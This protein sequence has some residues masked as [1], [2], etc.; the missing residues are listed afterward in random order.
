M[1]VSFATFANKQKRKNGGQP[2]FFLY[3]ELGNQRLL[4]L[5]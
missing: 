3:L 1:D 2:P 5:R 4:I